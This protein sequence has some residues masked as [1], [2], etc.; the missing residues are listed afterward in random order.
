MTD[1]NYFYAEYQ[2]LNV[3]VEYKISSY[4]CFDFIEKQYMFRNR[5]ISLVGSQWLVQLR[6]LLS[7]LIQKKTH[8]KRELFAFSRYSQCFG[9]VFQNHLSKRDRVL[10]LGKERKNWNTKRKK[11]WFMNLEKRKKIFFAKEKKGYMNEEK[12]RNKN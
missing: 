7:L 8:P 5:V 11:A 6:Y 2:L 9:K 1:F 12:I 3:T 4:G 10:C